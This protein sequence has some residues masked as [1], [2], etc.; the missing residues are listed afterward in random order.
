MQPRMLRRRGG[1]LGASLANCL[2]IVIL[3]ATA[4]VAAGM[5][6]VFSNPSLVE[7]IN[8][9]LP[10]H[11]EPGPT[12]P[13]T[14]GFPTRT[15]TPE[16]YLPP[17]WTHTPAP[18]DTP[19]ET[20]LPSDTPLPSETPTPLPSTGTPQ[21]TATGLPFSVQPGS[22]ILVTNFAND[23]GCNW[24]G[25]AGQV[26]D[27]SKAPYP[28]VTVHVEGQLAGQL[29]KIDTLTGSATRIGPAGY[30]FDLSDHPIASTGTLWI[31][32][33]DTAGLLLSDKVFFNT[34]AQCDQNMV[35]INW[36]QVR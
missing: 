13:P 15:N 29:V 10:V 16:I 21:P 17:T 24:M 23:D 35:F 8:P 22:N 19:T 32:L 33:K 18:S 14:L 2:T 4:A 31:Q 34:S 3:L 20:P 9:F 28:G 7:A 26:F 12:V 11:F 25:V 1:S 6:A 30:V 27:L 5:A 36:N